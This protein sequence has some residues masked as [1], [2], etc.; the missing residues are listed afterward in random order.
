MQNTLSVIHA[1]N[2]QK[3][4]ILIS[5]IEKIL[6]FLG[7]I[8]IFNSSLKNFS[9]FDVINEKQYEPTSLHPSRSTTAHRYPP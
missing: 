4:K 1:K 7:Q 6:G 9:C 5:K 8:V 2:A 3:R